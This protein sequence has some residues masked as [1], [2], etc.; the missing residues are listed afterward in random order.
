MENWEWRD[1]WG[2]CADFILIGRERR[3]IRSRGLRA[4]GLEGVNG[5]WRNGGMMMR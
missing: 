3:R 4:E 5:G 1:G 2:M